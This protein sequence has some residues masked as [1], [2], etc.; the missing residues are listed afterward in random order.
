MASGVVKLDCNTTSWQNTNW[1][2]G[3]LWSMRD[4]TCKPDT[5]DLTPKVS[6]SGGKH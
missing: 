1:T 2:I 5:L 6:H 4:T 3:E